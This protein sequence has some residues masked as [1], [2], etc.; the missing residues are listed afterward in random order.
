MS[1]LAKHAQQFEDM[2]KRGGFLFAGKLEEIDGDGKPSDT[3][4][5]TMRYL[6]RPEP[7][8]PIADIIKY[9]ENGEDKTDD[10][11]KKVDEKRA[12]RRKKREKEKDKLHL[13]FLPTE[14]PRY[15]FALAEHGAN[16][17]ARI[18]FFPKEP[19]D[20]A[21]K[22]SAWVDEQ[23]G[24]ILSMGFSLSKNPMFID[25]IEVQITFGLPTPLGRAPSQIAFDGRGGF[26]VIRKHFRGRAT[27]S[28]PQVAF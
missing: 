18:T 17:R 5:I 22:G 6:P 7:Q 21:I 23:S 13:P 4:E 28:E 9:L 16:N 3:K 12:E 2:K 14:Q 27:F 20:D 25:H 15:V 19:A 10:A 8:Q 11:R 26:L 24:E 1:G